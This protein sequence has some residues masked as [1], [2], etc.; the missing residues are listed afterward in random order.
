MLPVADTADVVQGSIML[1]LMLSI[2]FSQIP[3]A[4]PFFIRPIA[5]LIAGG[6]LSTFIKPRLRENFNFVNDS[7]AGK[8]FF[9]GDELTGADSTFLFLFWP[10][11]SYGIR[12][13]RDGEGAVVGGKVWS[14]DVF[15]SKTVMM[16]FPV[17]G[18]E[19]A[20]G[21]EAFP[22]IKSWFERVSTRP[23]YLRALEKGGANHLATF[24]Q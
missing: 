24:T 22:H 10:V 18:L 20:L 11:R 5:S 14:A 13:D 2:V 21:Y 23:A 12:A 4:T 15:V 9:V 16:V 8:Q 1:P 19:L 7:L 17:E 3:K 6:A